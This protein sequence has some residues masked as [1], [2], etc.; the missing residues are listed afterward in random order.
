MKKQDIHIGTSAF[1][2]G[3][4]KGVFYPEDL[5]RSKWFDYYCTQFNTYELNATFYRFPTVKSLQG[6]YNKT[7]E[8]FAFAVKAHKVITHFKKFNDCRHEI[9]G[10]YAIA[11]EGLR[12]KLGCVLFQLPPSF[13][14]SPEKL[15][16]ILS[17]MNPDFK[18]VIEFR[19]ESWWLQEVYD[20]LRKSNITFCSVSYPKLPLTIVKTTGTGYIRF[21]G[22]PKLFYSEYSAEELQQWHEGILRNDWKEVF[23]YFN[24]TASTAGIINALEM[25]KCLATIP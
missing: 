21:H 17:Y 9:D 23:V 15:E 12:E 1:S 5:P 19:N 2:N 10:F 16:L 3:Y 25:K 8:G 14:Y 6:W 20:A 13:A 24:N 18:N 4:W 22:V 11:K 7:P